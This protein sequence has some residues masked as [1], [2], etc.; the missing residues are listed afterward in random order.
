MELSRPTR[1]CARSSCCIS[2]LPAPTASNVLRNCI[3]AIYAGSGGLP[4]PRPAAPLICAKSACLCAAALSGSLSA[5]RF[6][7]T[8]AC[9][10][11]APFYCILCVK[12]H[13]NTKM[14]D[15]VF[16]IQGLF[17]KVKLFYQIVDFSL[18][19]VYFR[20]S[21][22]FKRFRME[23]YPNKLYVQAHKNYCIRFKL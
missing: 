7:L 21:S 20:V 13:Y 1:F 17:Q 23:I 15:I 9:S 3:P 11:A 16:I 19:F 5:R 2:L 8:K 6:F 12:P 4:L 22:I 18:Q 10:I 14:L